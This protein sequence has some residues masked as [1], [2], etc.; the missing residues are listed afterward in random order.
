M[1]GNMDTP[2]ETD[3]H[4]PAHR[5]THC[6][7]C[8]PDDGAWP[9]RGPLLVTPA[10]EKY[11]PPGLGNVHSQALADVAGPGLR[12]DLPRTPGPRKGL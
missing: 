3:I 12:T 5:W 1:P 10:L 8:T 6:E 7:V 11:G 9:T 2:A 4:G